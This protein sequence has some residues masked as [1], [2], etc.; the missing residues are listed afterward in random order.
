MTPKL[1]RKKQEQPVEAVQWMGENREEIER[2]TGFTMSKL[3]P[4]VQAGDW[5]LRRRDSTVY[6][7]RDTVFQA[8]Y[9]PVE[10]GEPEGLEALLCPECGFGHIFPSTAGVTS[11]VCNHDHGQR[12]VPM[13]L[14]NVYTSQ[15]HPVVE[16]G[17]E[18]GL[19]EAQDEATEL[20]EQSVERGDRCIALERQVVNQRR[21]LARAQQALKEIREVHQDERLRADQ[22][23]DRIEA[24]Y[25]SALAD[26]ATPQPKEGEKT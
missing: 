17:G 5:V 19:V 16:E 15:P 8:T 13:R 26:P 14:T 4:G 11:A 12:K 24:V 21:D 6:S 23:L 7:L 10:E 2:L 18:D 20:R 9:E 1:Y 22:A 25:V 3:S